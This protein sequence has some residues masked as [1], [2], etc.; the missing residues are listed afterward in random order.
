MMPVVTGNPETDS[1]LEYILHEVQKVQ[2]EQRASQEVQRTLK[3]ELRH[4]ADKLKD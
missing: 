1:A 3:D 2:G 4:A